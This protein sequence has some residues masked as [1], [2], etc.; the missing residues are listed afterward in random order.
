M[1]T[2]A[3]KQVAPDIYRL[4]GHWKTELL[5]ERNGIYFDGFREDWL[6]VERAIRE[7]NSYQ[8]LS[9]TLA[10][11]SMSPLIG[12]EIGHCDYPGFVVVLLGKDGEVFADRIDAAL[13]A[14]F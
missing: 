13:T 9:V 5:A 3:I 10:P 12:V 14:P 8:S 4:V 7:K 11:F 6:G 1:S 2:I